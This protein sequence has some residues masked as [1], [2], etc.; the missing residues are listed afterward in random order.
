M[1]QLGTFSNDSVKTFRCF[2]PVAAYRED[3][4]IGGRFP[5]FMRKFVLCD[6]SPLAHRGCDVSEKLRHQT[7]T[8]PAVVC[9]RPVLYLS[10]WKGPF[11]WPVLTNCPC[12]TGQLLKYTMNRTTMAGHR[13]RRAHRARRALSNHV[14]NAVELG[15][16]RESWRMRRNW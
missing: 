6:F 8:C 2:I 1:T 16:A 3:V 10:T 11:L 12:S 4:L 14:H 13:P 7:R 5:L 9:P 15:I